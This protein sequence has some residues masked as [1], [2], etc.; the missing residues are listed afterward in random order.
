MIISL[1][2]PALPALTL[3][4]HFAR[5]VLVAEFRLSDICDPLDDGPVYFLDDFLGGGVTRASCHNQFANAYLRAQ[6]QVNTIEIDAAI[7]HALTLH[8]AGHWQAFFNSQIN[9]PVAAPRVIPADIL[10]GAAH[11]SDVSPSSLLTDPNAAAS[12][13]TLAAVAEA[14]DEWSTEGMAGAR[15]MDPFVE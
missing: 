8:R 15:P 2:R 12:D 3:P 1:L 4:H 11:G 9:R 10:E 13:A 7:D 6:L 14:A 5:G